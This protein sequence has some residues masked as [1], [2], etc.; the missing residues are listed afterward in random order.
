MGFFNN[1]NTEK[2]LEELKNLLKNSFENVKNDTS[3]IFEWLNYF[4]QKVYQQQVLINDLKAQLQY[5]PKTRQDIR[6]LIDTY[7]SINPILHKID[8][9]KAKIDAL[10]A[11]KTA[12]REHIYHHDSRLQTLEK[13]KQN[14]KEK[15][16]KKISKSSKDYVKNII[17]NL[18]RKYE[19][20]SALQLRDI[21]VDEQVLCSKSSFY[22]LLEEIE[23]D[24]EIG[25]IHDKKEKKYVYKAIKLK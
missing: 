25:V 4:N 14:F 5:M 11:E 6:D 18:I 15:L 19:N 9:I 24:E 22:R 10:E 12:V 23:Q 13:P 2:E 3:S 1:K 16:V 21:I 7:Y 17:L 8:E 20:I